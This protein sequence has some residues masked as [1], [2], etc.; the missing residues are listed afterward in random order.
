MYVYIYIIVQYQWPFSCSVPFLGVPV[1]RFSHCRRGSFRCRAAPL[2][3]TGGSGKD[4]GTTHKDIH[5]KKVDSF[6]GA[7]NGDD[8]RCMYCSILL[9]YHLI[10]HLIKINICQYEV[11]I[12]QYCSYTATPSRWVPDFGYGSDNPISV[13]QLAGRRESQDEMDTDGYRIDSKK[14]TEFLNHTHLITIYS[15]LYNSYD[16][17]CGSGPSF[18]AWPDQLHHVGPC[19]TWITWSFLTL[20]ASCSYCFIPVFSGIPSFQKG[21]SLMGHELPRRHRATPHFLQFL[22]QF[23]S[24]STLSILFWSF[25]ALSLS[26]TA[27][28]CRWDLKQWSD[29]VYVVQLGPLGKQLPQVTG[30]LWFCCCRSFTCRGFRRKWS[31]CWWIRMSQ[32]HCEW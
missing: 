11:S 23:P 25:L 26:C 28:C 5:W 8:F 3:F 12:D 29:Q 32:A 4:E 6:W 19:C 22:E 13:L 1:P 17:H 31:W 27:A 15:W 20:A 7:H 2:E 14:T 18:L 16:F 9:V 10:Y 21:P 24:V 30:L